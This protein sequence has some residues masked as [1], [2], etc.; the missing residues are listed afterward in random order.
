[1]LLKASRNGKTATDHRYD[2]G[3]GQQMSGTG[4]ISFVITALLFL[5]IFFSPLISVSGE[6]FT[7]NF[8]P[9]VTIEST[10]SPITID[11]ELT[12][13]AWSSATKVTGFSEFEPG[14]NVQPPVKT[15]VFITYDQT[16]LYLGF[17]AHDDPSKI[18]ASYQDRD[19]AFQDDF[20]G[21]LI[22]TYGNASWAYEM[23]AN[24][25]GIQM[26]GRWM[27]SGE[28]MSFDLLFHTEGRITEQGYQVEFAIPFRSLRF[29]DNTS[30][31]WRIT[32]IR[33][34]PRE[35]RGQY[36]WAALDRDNP[37]VLCQLGYLRGM[38]NIQ[39][40]RNFEFLPETVVSQAGERSDMDDPVSEF[41]NDPV[42][43]EV[44]LGIKYGITPTLTAD[45]AFNPDYS[46]VEADPAQIDVNTTFALHF[47]ERRPFFQEGSDLFDTYVNAVYTR[48]INDPIVAAKLTGRM[49]NWSLAYIGARDRQ[50]P[51]LVPFEEESE[52]VGAEKSIPSVSNIF[53]AQRNLGNDS[54]LGVLL[55]DRR[56]DNGG[57]GSL[58]SA[59]GGLRFLRNYRVEWQLLGSHTVEPSD[60]SLSSDFPDL[61]FGKEDH[62]AVFDGES[63]SGHALYAELSRDARHWDWDLN[64][65]EYSPAFRAANGFVTKNNN[66][67]IS[68]STDYEFRPESNLVKNLSPMINVGREWNYQ[69]VRKDEWIRPGFWGQFFGQTNVAGG[70]I[71]SSERFE[72]LEF[73]GLR[74]WELNINSNFSDILK[75]GF[76]ISSGETVARN[77][78]PPIS[79]HSVRL[80]IWADI[81]PSQRLIVHPDYD[82]LILKKKD[83]TTL[84]DDFIFR[85]RINYQLTRSLYL[86]VVTQYNGFDDQ[87]EIDPLLTYRIN[88]F[89]VIYLG[90]THDFKEYDRPADFRQMSRQIFFKVRYLFQI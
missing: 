15:E 49:Q 7:S 77:E 38:R 50:S 67:E 21:V 12:D 42:Q 86:R 6:E 4:N 64:Y 58:L 65:E 48:S 82:H 53:R 24:P 14:D 72:D 68:V 13:G 43:G 76:Y 26:D 46:Q 45:L 89:S 35:H 23:F 10:G 18:R 61:R 73:T 69:G 85:T 55:T 17:V 40:G 88:A 79:A 30:P 5:G 60:T 29:P 66:R 19:Q 3:F 62:T 59:D 31:S 78:D 25:Y 28:D 63:F 52:T 51:I 9:E 47:P 8:K 87:L 75:P 81:K 41:Q 22:D 80:S 36:S 57:S 71:I 34:H 37:C 27:S 11:G 70:Y 39:S 20:V 54:F 1:M 90:S 74:R 33:T 44:S 16:H 83:G 2:N 56:L 32:F 84:N